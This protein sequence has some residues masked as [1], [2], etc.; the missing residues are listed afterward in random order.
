LFGHKSAAK[1]QNKYETE[2]AEVKK[3]AL[4]GKNKDFSFV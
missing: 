1:L 4:G 3:N 2:K